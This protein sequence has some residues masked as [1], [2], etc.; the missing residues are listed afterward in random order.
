MGLCN[1]SATFTAMMNEVLQGY[2]ENFCTLYLD[3][4]LIFSKTK[5]E[6]RKHVRKVLEKLQMHKLYPSPQEL[7][8]YD[9]GSRISWNHGF[10]EGAIRKS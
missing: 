6:H 10:Y 7:L 3:D 9:S 5:E 4:I 2:E 8:F 1:A